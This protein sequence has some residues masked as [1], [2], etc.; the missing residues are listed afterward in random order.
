MML[1]LLLLS[2][3]LFLLLVVVVTGPVRT[4][5]AFSFVSPPKYPRTSSSSSC[6]RSNTGSNSN[7]HPTASLNHLAA[8]IDNNSDVEEYVDADEYATIGIDDWIDITGDGGV[9]KAAA[10]AE[11]SSSPVDGTDITMSYQGTIQNGI[12]TGGGWTVEEVIQCWLAEQ[13]GLEENIAEVFR[14][15]ALDEAKLCDTTSFFTE[16]Y[17]REN[18]GIKNKIGGKKLLMAVKRLKKARSGL[19][20]DGSYPYGHIFDTQEQYP[21]TLGNT[22]LIRGMDLGLR[23]MVSN[24]ETSAFLQI[25]S[26]YGYGAEGYRKTTGEIMIPPYATLCFLSNY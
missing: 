22:K 12:T 19:A 4:S 3:W 20:A 13:Q 25:R 21:V 26:D 5:C 16:D 8:S 15:E 7:I 24:Q 2:S 10:D 23:T 17:I 9:R 11:P 14:A 18:L 1:Y 6:S